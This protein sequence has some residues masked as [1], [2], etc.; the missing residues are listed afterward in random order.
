[1]SAAPTPSTTKAGLLGAAER[2]ASKA[3]ANLASLAIVLIMIV[4]VV[5]VVTRGVS[6]RSVPGMIESAEIILVAAAVLG[7]GYAQRMKAHVSTSIFMDALPPAMAHILRRAGLLVVVVGGHAASASGETRGLEEIGGVDVAQKLF[8]EHGDGHRDVAE[9]LAGAGA[10]DRR[11]C[12]VTEI[13]IGGHFKDG[14]LHGVA[15]C[16]GGGLG[17]NGCG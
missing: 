13:A 10:R 5:D 4:T 15:G 11:H 6:A 12:A 17:R 7:L 8:R 9:I 3:G 16:G 14:Q 1:M 2:N